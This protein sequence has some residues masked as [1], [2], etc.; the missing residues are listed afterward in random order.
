MN[1]Y[2][3]FLS[4]LARDP[5]LCGDAAYSSRIMGDVMVMVME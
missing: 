3:Y 2:F 4:Q 1:W 5:S